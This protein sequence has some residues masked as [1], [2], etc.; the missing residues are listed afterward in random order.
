L[1][2]VFGALTSVKGGDVAVRTEEGLDFFVSHVGGQVLDENVV[3]GLSLIS[4]ALRVELYTNEV[5]LTRGGFESFSCVFRV[6][7]ANESITT[8]GVLLIKRH[9]AGD[10]TSKLLEIFLQVIGFHGLVDLSDKDVLLLQ[11]GKIDSEQVLAVG[12]STTGLRL[13]LEV[14]EV[15]LDSFELV[16]VVDSD[17]S[18]VEGLIDISAD[19]GLLDINATLLLDESCELGGGVVVLGQI[20]EVDNVLLARW[21]N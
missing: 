19:L 14:A 8:G 13:E 11:L 3:E 15:L 18:G 16:S 1:G 4:A 12:E 21:E 20:V 10:D 6:L 2:W 7:V 5:F 17:D 9:L